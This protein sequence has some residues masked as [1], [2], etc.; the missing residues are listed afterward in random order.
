VRILAVD[1]SSKILALGISDGAKIYEYNL[2]VGVR[3]SALLIPAIKRAVDSLGWRMRDIDYFA[4]GLGPGSFTG[5]RVGLSTIKGLAWSLDKPVAGISSLD[6][7]AANVNKGSGFIIP[8]V[9]AKRNLI[10][11]SGYRLQSGRLKR[12]M[13]YSLLAPQDLAAGIKNKMRSREILFLGDGLVLHK[14]KI[15][16]TVRGTVVL[17]RDYWYP[18]ARNLLALAKEK[19]AKKDLSSAFKIGPVYLYPKDCQVR[20]KHGKS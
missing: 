7:L 9:D 19:I 17:D 5:V 8:V 2:E 20:K 10:Y 12:I 4:C 11:S 6:V 18:Q 14:E 3:L 13:P 1:T 16:N 15:L